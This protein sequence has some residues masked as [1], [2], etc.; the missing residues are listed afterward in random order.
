M[1]VA[2]EICLDA[3]NPRLLFHVR[4]LPPGGYV[5]ERFDVKPGV[6]VRELE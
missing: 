2:T 5:T 6:L 1:P 3:R 4:T